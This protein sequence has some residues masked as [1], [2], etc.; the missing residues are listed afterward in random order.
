M[1][2]GVELKRGNEYE[3]RS[4]MTA[5]LNVKL[6]PQDDEKSMREA[7]ALIEQY[8]AIQ[9]YYYGDFYPLTPYSQSPDAWMAYQLDLPESGEGL[10]V[11][12]K[13][14]KSTQKSQRLRLFGL[15]RGASYDVTNLDSSESG[16]IAGSALADQG[17]E[18][19][20]AG[21]P[22]SALV[23]YSRK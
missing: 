13:R 22:D 5:G 19:M 23:R 9:K 4:A 15:D 1:S 16:K 6:P 8:L 20:L 11:V 3:I 10:L 18:V 12:L 7:K 17:L 21:Q 14:P 2:E